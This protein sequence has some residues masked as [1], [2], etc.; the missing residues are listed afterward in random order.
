M[1]IRDRLP[2]VGHEGLLLIPGGGYD[3][4]QGRVAPRQK[5]VLILVEPVGLHLL[6]HDL[7]H[8]PAGNAAVDDTLG[9]V[10][11]VWK[12]LRI[13][14]Q[15][16]HGLQLRVLVSHVS[17]NIQSLVVVVEISVVGNLYGH[18][19]AKLDRKNVG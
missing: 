16:L 9:R 11:R 12:E 6:L 13:I 4:I 10:L 19:L 14:C 3:G 18:N 2:V 7:G 5:V 17:G 15:I 1:C 8:F